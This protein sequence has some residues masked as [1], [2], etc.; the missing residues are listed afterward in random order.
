MTTSIPSIK[1]FFLWEVDFIHSSTNLPVTV[2]VLTEKQDI[3]A[4]IEQA[5]YCVQ[6]VP[7]EEGRTYVFHRQQVRAMRMLSTVHFVPHL[8]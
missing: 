3:P 5:A 4:V 6:N 7:G 1:R 8:N 2:T